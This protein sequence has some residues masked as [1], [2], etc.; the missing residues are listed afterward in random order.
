MTLLV[1]HPECA[2]TSRAPALAVS[3]PP[4][5]EAW[6]P[7][8]EPSPHNLIMS[9]FFGPCGLI[10]HHVH[11]R[12]L[13]I[14]VNSL[15]SILT[16]IIRCAAPLVHQLNRRPP[17]T[18]PT[19]PQTP[20]PT[21]PTPTRRAHAAA[22]QA[23]SCQELPHLLVDR[24]LVTLAIGLSVLPQFRSHSY[25]KPKD[26]RIFSM[27][28]EKYFMTLIIFNSDA[29]SLSGCYPRCS[30]KN[31]SRYYETDKIH[32]RWKLYQW[33]WSIAK[34]ESNNQNG[35][36]RCFSPWRGGGVSSSTYLFWK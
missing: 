4:S 15:W 23:S 7:R 6:C 8:S 32:E 27:N 29:F 10:N 30:C 17:P 24:G 21:R 25:S 5:W 13:M 22:V 35:N 26:C 16:E 31:Q 12:P 9:S 19:P 33:S 3:T 2:G 18:P 20:R 36:L 1:D 11:H 14:I 28:G 34:G